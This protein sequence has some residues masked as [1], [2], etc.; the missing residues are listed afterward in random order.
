MKLTIDHL[1]LLYNV[2]KEEDLTCINGEFY[3]TSKDE[4][5]DNV[6]RPMHLFKN[7]RS[8]DIIWEGEGL[9][10]IWHNKGKF[11]ILNSIQIFEKATK[12]NHK[13][14]L[15]DEVEIKKAIEEEFKNINLNYLYLVWEVDQRAQLTGKYRDLILLD[16]HYSNRVLTD[17]EVFE[18]LEFSNPDAH[19]YRIYEIRDLEPEDLAEYFSQKDLAHF[20]L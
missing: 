7:N 15:G 20:L 18:L 4:L 9:Y 11:Q 12:M 2:A 1:I 10:H 5:L 14:Y 6:V 16:S 8:M 3:V 17:S 13:I 19:N